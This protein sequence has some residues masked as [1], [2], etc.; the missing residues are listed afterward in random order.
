ALYQGCTVFAVQDIGAHDKQG[1]VLAYQFVESARSGFPGPSGYDRRL[2][3]SG[4]DNGVA[5]LPIMVNVESG[6]CARSDC[7]K[8]L[9]MA[10]SPRELEGSVT[11]PAMM[12]KRVGVS[13]RMGLDAEAR[14]RC[15]GST[16][17]RRLRAMMAW[18]MR[19][20]LRIIYPGSS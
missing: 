19:D 12:A 15:R 8:A 9:N 17:C 18:S 6:F 4:Y 20:C 11:S 3:N 7:I 16:T 1:M 10:R 2:A 14:N 5:A 13:G